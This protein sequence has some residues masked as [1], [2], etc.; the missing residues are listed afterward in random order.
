MSQ[1][2]KEPNI[3]RLAQ[4]GNGSSRKQGPRIKEPLSHWHTYEGLVAEDAT[5]DRMGPT[6]VEHGGSGSGCGF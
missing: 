4:S 1:K 6:P 2:D 5:R 3:G